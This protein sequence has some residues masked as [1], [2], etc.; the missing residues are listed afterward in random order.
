MPRFET[1]G[2]IELELDL[3][4]ADV[5]VEAGD[6]GDTV[7]EVRASDEAKRDDVSAAERTRVESTAGR[8]VVRT[9]KSW[10][11]WSPFGYGGAIE[12]SVQLPVGSRVAASCGMGTVRGNGPLGHSQIKTGLGDIH[13]E[14]AVS[15][16]LTTGMGDIEIGHVDGQADLSTGSGDIRAGE[17]HGPVLIKNANGDVRV[18]AVSRGS[19]DARTGFGR[20]DIG[21]PRGT[22]A[23][24][25]LG[26]GYGEVCNGLERSGPPAPGEPSVQVRA[27]SGYGDI[28]INPA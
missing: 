3:A 1:T 22:A 14:R 17:L 5:R 16:R 13:V 27:R 28:T 6:R 15:A 21:V 10:R 20:I 26:T 7:I 24:L 23:W 12:V 9:P 8:V 19:V 2:S 25:D 4:V 18:G 11:T